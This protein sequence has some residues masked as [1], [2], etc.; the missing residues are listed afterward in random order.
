MTIRWSEPAGDAIE[1]L[2]T[3]IA[4][5]RGEAIAARIVDDICRLIERL[6]AYP[7]MGREGRV[8]G[9]RE[10]PHPPHV[11]VYQIVGDVINILD[12][13]DARRQR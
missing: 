10:L 13:F 1:N 12:V 7:R 9:T 8:E 2:Y 6:K 5:N 3:Y 11:I 4:L